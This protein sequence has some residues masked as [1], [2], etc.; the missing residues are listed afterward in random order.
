MAEKH[1]DNGYFSPLSFFVLDIVLLVFVATMNLLCTVY[2]SFLSFT[3]L[4]T[5]SSFVPLRTTTTFVTRRSHVVDGTSFVTSSVVCH[6][7]GTSLSSKNDDDNNNNPPDPLDELDEER[8]A[9]LFQF[10]LRDY[11]V[12]GVPLLAV[13]ADQVHTLQAAIWTTLAELSETAASTPQFDNN[14]ND[15]P[16]NIQKACLIFEDIPI[17]ALRSFVDDF[18]LLKTQERLMKY[19][20]ELEQCSLSLVGK[21]VGPAILLQVSAPPVSL[22]RTVVEC[23]ETTLIAAMKH[24]VDRLGTKL[25]PMMMMMMMTQSSPNVGTGIPEPVPVAYRVSTSTSVCTILSTFWNCICELVATPPTQLGTTMMIL[26]GL[27]N[28]NDNNQARFGAVSE[29][30]SRSLSLYR[31]DDVFEVL[32]FAPH[33]DRTQIHPIDKPAHGHIPPLQ[34][35]RPMLRHDGKTHEADTLSDD[36]LQLSNYQR[37]SPVTAVCIKRTS[38]IDKAVEADDGMVDLDLGDGQVVKASGIPT[39]SRNALE[40]AKLGASALESAL[41]AE[42]AVAQGS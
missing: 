1:L 10:L 11:Q 32:H 17:Q 42:I 27:D 28:N 3:L 30:I 40:L 13:D 35:L 18:M 23:Q 33:Y 41:E 26:P 29:L 38:L 20:P 14:D 9:N 4:T 39:Y 16:E 21:G 24:F 34:W 25:C 5:I 12:E 7:H 2:C 6:H 19:L 36:D 8:K 22:T 15:N 37:R 31:G